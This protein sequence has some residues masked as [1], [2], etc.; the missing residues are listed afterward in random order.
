MLRFDVDR[1]VRRR[2]V[3]LLVPVAIA[4]AMHLSVL[5]ARFAN[6][7]YFLLLEYLPYSI[8]DKVSIALPVLGFLVALVVVRLR[9]RSSV[10][11]AETG[12]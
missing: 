6:N 12:L 5:P 7:I 8:V 10:H 2:A 1:Q 4:M 9:E 3:A 11:P